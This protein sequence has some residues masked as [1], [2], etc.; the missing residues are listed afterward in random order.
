MLK[1]LKINVPENN[2][3]PTRLCGWYCLAEYA[4]FLGLSVSPVALY[5]QVK[6]Y[7]Y[8]APG[9]TSN[10]DQL[11]IGVKYI[12]QL[13]GA[14]GIDW[15]ADQGYINDPNAIRDAVAKDYCVIAG[16]QESVLIPG[17]NY[18][19]FVV[20]RSIDANLDGTAEANIADSYREIDGG[21]DRYDW[22]TFV[23]AMAANW[24]PNCDALGFKVVFAPPA[25]T[26]NQP[27]QPTTQDLTQMEQAAVRRY[28]L[29]GI[30]PLTV[31]A[32]FKA[33]VQRFTLWANGNH[34]N[35]CDPTPAIQPET[36]L[37]NGF[38]YAAF[39]CGEIYE[40]NPVTHIVSIAEH[41][42]FE[43][44]YAACGWK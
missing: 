28:S 3:G 2:Q 31:G 22:G 13:A 29:L 30:K 41:K 7:A 15:Y 17:Q 25:P 23:S 18:G 11:F 38:V 27:N 34:S 26:P 19:H 6:G 44:I 33:Y 10:F 9:D 5:E 16:I 40:Y 24:N 39:D 14:Q 21:T 12:Q 43:K 4:Q 8:V 42:D 20:I 37:K 36:T 32:I 1:P 35:V